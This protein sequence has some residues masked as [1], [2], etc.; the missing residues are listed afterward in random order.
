MHVRAKVDVEDG[1]WTGDEGIPVLNDSD[2]D[3][4]EVGFSMWGGGKRGR[5]RT[6]CGERLE[7]V[8]EQ[9][10]VIDRIYSIYCGRSDSRVPLASA[11][12]G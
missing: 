4:D 5:R 6:E 11:T 12:H 9:V 3:A 10:F 1:Q 2:V 8:D 7:E